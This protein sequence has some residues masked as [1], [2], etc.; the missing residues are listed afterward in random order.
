MLNKAR[1][2]TPG[3]T[4][5]PDSV[6]LAMAQDMIHHRKPAFKALMAELQK[7][8]QLLFGTTQPVLPLACSGT[9]AMTAAVT[10][11]FA[12]KDRVLVVEGGKFGQRWSAIARSHD[13]HVIPIE[14]PWG[15]AVEPQI[16][17]NALTAHP[18]ATGLLVQCSETSTGVM[19]PVREIAACTRKTDTL[20]VVDGIS[21]VGIAPC[22]MDAWG[23]DCLLTGSQKGLLLPPGLALIAL[24]QRAWTRAAQHPACFYFN[25]PA[26][27]AKA[28]SHQTLFTTPV[29][30]IM[31]LRESM[32]LYAQVGHADVFRKQWALTQL[33][34]SG[35]TAMG[36]PPLV[37]R[38][39]AWGL[40]TV[41]LPGG[42]DASAV[43]AYAA[44]HH[45]VILAGGQDQFKG[46]I[47]RIGHM[48]W[49]DWADLIAGL[50]ALATGFR[51]CGGYIGC[52]DYLEQALCAYQEAL[53]IPSEELLPA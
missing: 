14:V 6:R 28:E 51:A 7:N 41:A 4:P 15:Q 23:V 26:E 27:R 50:H 24:S 39:Y 2:L 31:G 44:E 29:S 37:T 43:I 36:L 35:L 49:V 34:R 53:R 8:L 12:P 17:A 1:M 3:P 21:S 18:D 33:T 9:G 52:R 38:H 30:L 5:I 11:L 46:R 25:L 47:I 45:G 40:T 13:L 48:G 19:H 16:V 20:L 22:P 10:N 32:R 42:L